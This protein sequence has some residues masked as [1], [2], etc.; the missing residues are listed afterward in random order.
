M[1]AVWESEA[2]DF[3]ISSQGLVRYKDRVCVPNDQR[4][5]MTILEKAHNTPYL[6]H[7]GSTK[8]TRDNKENYW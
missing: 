1:D 5:K 2:M 7:P 3:S 8:M 4:I 6:A